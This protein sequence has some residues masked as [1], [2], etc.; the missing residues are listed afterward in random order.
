MK[1]TGQFSGQRREPKRVYAS[2]DDDEWERVGRPPIDDFVGHDPH[3]SNR[4]DIYSLPAD[5]GLINHIA[6]KVEH[7]EVGEE[8]EGDEQ[9]FLDWMNHK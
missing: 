6:R 3:S 4:D 7:V 1:F 8:N 9:R 5:R 2:G